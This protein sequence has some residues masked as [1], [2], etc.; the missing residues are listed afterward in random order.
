MV[1][2]VALLGCHALLQRVINTLQIGRMPRFRQRIVAH[3]ALYLCEIPSSIHGSPQAVGSDLGRTGCACAGRRLAPLVADSVARTGTDLQQT[4]GN[5][6][7]REGEGIR[8]VQL[9][10]RVMRGT[11]RQRSPARTGLFSIDRRR[12]RL[13]A[14]DAVSEHP[15][16]AGPTT[17]IVHQPGAWPG[18]HDEQGDERER[19]GDVA[20]E[21]S[22]GRRRA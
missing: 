11:G 16:I 19:T 22:N 14:V 10:E 15:V 8:L 7:D 18:D 17:H 20:Q 13:D 12:E 9:P 3:E 1:P 2:E 4:G 21:A 5:D 6:V